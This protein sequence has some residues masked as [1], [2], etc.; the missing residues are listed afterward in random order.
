MT[1]DRYDFKGLGII[2]HTYFLFSVIFHLI[3]YPTKVSCFEFCVLPNCFGTVPSLSHPVIALNLV[4]LMYTMVETMTIVWSEIEVKTDLAKDQIRIYSK[5]TGIDPFLR[6]GFYTW[7]FIAGS[8]IE[9]FIVRILIGMRECF[10][11]RSHQAY[12]KMYSS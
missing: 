6:F 11:I 8:K 2:L 9:N 10:V 12:W 4:L 5:A 3:C 7:F 1:K